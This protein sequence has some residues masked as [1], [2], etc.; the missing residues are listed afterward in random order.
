MCDEDDFK[1]G[2]KALRAVTILWIR[3]VGP[4]HFVNDCI[5]DVIY[6][7]MY[8]KLEIKMDEQFRS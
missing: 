6:I 5:G 8:F 7:K 3:N 4:K 2:K 1:G